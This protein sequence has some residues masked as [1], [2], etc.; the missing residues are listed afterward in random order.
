MELRTRLAALNPT[1][2]VSANGVG[3]PAVLVTEN[4]S[5][6]PREIAANCFWLGFGAAQAVRGCEGQSPALMTME[7]T[8]TYRTQAW[9]DGS[10]RG[11]ALTALDA[12]LLTIWSPG[13][14]EKMDY[15][16]TPASG[17]G[18]NVFWLRPKLGEVVDENG[19]LRR[20][21][22]LDLFFYPEEGS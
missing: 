20:E 14:T 8:V 22:K 19:T 21:A 7:C 9:L 6:T 13:M 2:T 1:R 11:R 10:N 12:E 16:Q 17:L 4:S 5:V 18:S 15:T 3:Q